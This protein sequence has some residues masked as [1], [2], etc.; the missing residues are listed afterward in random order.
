MF[1]SELRYTTSMHWKRRIKMFGV[2]DRL[3]NVT[4]QLE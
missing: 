2:S 3:L 1:N 4:L